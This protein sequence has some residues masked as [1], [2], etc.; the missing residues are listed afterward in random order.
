VPQLREHALQREPRGEAHADL[1]IAG[2]VTGA[3]EHEVAQAGEAREGLGTPA[4]CGAQARDFGEAARDERSARV[5][6][7]REPVADAGGDG[8]H[9]LECAAHLDADQVVARI[10]AQARAVER[11]RRLGCEGL[12]A[13]GHYHGGG[14]PARDL[15]REAGPGERRGTGASRQGLLDDLVRQRSGRGLEALAGPEKAG[16]AT[17]GRERLERGAQPR[18]GCGD[19]HHLRVAGCARE[20]GLDADRAGNPVSGEIAARAPAFEGLAIGRGT[21]PQRHRVL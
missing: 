10:D 4:H 19:D 20:I 21:R 8:D 1:A 7:E 6:A 5:A 18:G 15:E 17:R 2:K 9:V 3:R 11:R 16:R 13:R 12:V 14:L